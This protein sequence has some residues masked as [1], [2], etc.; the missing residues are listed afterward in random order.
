MAEHLSFP[1]KQDNFHGRAENDGEERPLRY[2]NF[3]LDREVVSSVFDMAIHI[4]PNVRSQGYIMDMAPRVDT[5][6][7]PRVDRVEAIYGHWAEAADGSPATRYSMKAVYERQPLG[8]NDPEAYRPMADEAAAM[9][10]A[11]AEVRFPSET[12]GQ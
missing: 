10:M 2:V 11:A 4:E 12:S 9:I 3:R 7:T 5:Q 8:S 1:W 6:P